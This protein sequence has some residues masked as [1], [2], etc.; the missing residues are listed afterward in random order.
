MQHLKCILDFID[1]Y[2]TAKTTQ[3]HNVDYRKAYF[4]DLW[5]LYRPGD[6][7]IGMD[8][9]QAYRVIQVTSTRHR[10]T[11]RKSP[12]YNY[13]FARKKDDAS[14]KS[15]FTITCVYIDFDGKYIGPV[16]RTF[17]I[18]RFDGE[19]DI[20]SFEVYPLRLHKLNR[21]HFSEEEWSELRTYPEQDQCRRSLINRGDKFVAVAAVKHMYY[22]GPTMVVREEVESQ[23]VIDFETAFATEDDLQ[24]HIKRPSLESFIGETFDSKDTEES[25][26]QICACCRFDVVYNDDTFVDKNQRN[27]YINSLLPKKLTEETPSVALFPR[28]FSEIQGVSS[29]QPVFSEDE[30]VIMSYRVFGFVL[31]SRKW[32]MRSSS[33]PSAS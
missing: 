22:S 20:T 8:G 31:R 6:E 27:E 2:I 5:Y 24:E 4:S 17:E 1:N 16:L 23:V 26:D 18:K 29:N 13:Q 11:A 21:S 9:K 3:I 30:L 28:L 32:G 12:Y 14:E 25:P 7:V 15:E 33:P 10:P 19:R